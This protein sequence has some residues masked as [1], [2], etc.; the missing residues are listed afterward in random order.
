MKRG[1]IHTPRPAGVARLAARATL[2]QAPVPNWFALAPAD[3]DCLGNDVYGNC[4]DAADCRLIQLWGGKIDKSIALN[5]YRQMTGFN[6]VTGLPDNGSDTSADMASWC[7]APILDLDGKPWPI[8]WASVDH[9]DEEE[10]LAALARLPLAVTIGLP[11]AIADSPERWSEAPQ[12]D[13][14]AGEGHRV[15]LGSAG[16][17]GWRVRSWGRDYTVSYDLM[18]LMLLAVDAPIP[19]RAAAP[20]ELQWSG[21]DYTALE[22]D[23]ATLT[24]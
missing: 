9:T 24:A 20:A 11:A 12:H 16:D 4:V 1:A 23:L 8:Y 10:I 13:W 22:A 3:G 6:L 14:T 19:H 21:L 7:A 15:V 5:R 17:R 2:A 18:R